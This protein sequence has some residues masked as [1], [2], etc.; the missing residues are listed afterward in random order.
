[1]EEMAV[2]SHNEPEPSSS[3]EDLSET[4]SVPAHVTEPYRVY[5][6]RWYILFLFSLLACFQCQVWNTW[7]PIEVPVRYAYEWADSTVAMMANWGTIMF[8][9]TA[10]PLSYFLEV[11]GLRDTAILVT[12]LSTIGTVIRI[13]PLGS[14][15]FTW[16][17][18]ICAIL[19]GISGVTVM[20]APPVISAM[21]FPPNERA[22]ATAIA[23][24]GNQ[25]GTGVAYV[26]GPWM[27][28]DHQIPGRFASGFASA[29]DQRMVRNQIEWYMIVTAGI[30][31]T[32]LTFMVAYFPSRPEVPP[33]PS[34]HMARTDYKSGLLRIGKNGSVWLCMLA[35]AL[36]GGI[37]GAW[38]AVMTLNFEPLGISDEETGT[39][40]F[41]SVIVCGVVTIASCY[42]LD[43][44]RRHLKACILAFLG[45]SAI[46][47]SW[48]ALLCLG[49]I[50]FSKWQLYVATIGGISCNFATSPLYFELAVDLAYPVSEGLVATFLTTFNNLVGI[51]FLGV[52]FIPNITFT[53]MN[54]VLMASSLTGIPLVLMI[55]GQ[56]RRM[57]ADE[58]GDADEAAG[59]DLSYRVLPSLPIPIDSSVT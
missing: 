41:M 57:D 15:Y 25:M 21:W 24:V 30:F 47:F 43:R 53:W 28:P 37:N 6:K 8:V 40:A 17:S 52:F 14:T 33:S 46:F 38:S 26:L 42:V 3:Q 2:A 39:I 23:Q 16:S 7:G 19:N 10:I 44:I 4:D 48:L 22:T 49:F 32:I 51:V 1:M 11:Q 5:K 55:N 31:T 45:L 34:A 50:P 58:G 13:F 54:Y 36:P 56:M 29:P 35:Y 12:G 18:H 9:T 59:G 27:A 20:S